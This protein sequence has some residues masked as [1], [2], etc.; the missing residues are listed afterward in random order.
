MWRRRWRILL[1][2]VVAAVAM[3]AWSASNDAVYEAEALLVV[4]SGETNLDDAESTLLGENVAELV[5]T[6]PVLL[7]AAS[8]AGLDL[9]ASAARGRLSAASGVGSYVSVHATGPSPEEARALADG[10]AAA[11]DAAIDAQQQRLADETREPLDAEVERVRQALAEALQGVPAGGPE[12]AA[13]TALRSELDAV[14]A[15]RAR[16][17]A[18]P[19]ITVVTVQPASGGGQIE[20]TPARDAAVIFVIALVVNGELAVLLDLLSGRFSPSTADQEVVEQLGLPVL[21]RI[22]DA[23]ADDRTEPFRTLRTNL[24]FLTDERRTATGEAPVSRRSGQRLRSVAVLSP[25][26]GDGRTT[27]VAGL[28]EAI[29]GAGITVVAIDGDL[30]DPALHSRFG[31]SRQPGLGDVAPGG[32]LGAVRQSVLGLPGLGVVPAGR[33]VDDPSG[34]LSMLQRSIDGLPVELV[35]V[36]TP[37]ASYAEATAVAAQCDITL[38][39][40]DARTASKGQVQ[41]LLRYLE[42]TDARPAGVVLNRVDRA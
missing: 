36:D 2:S 3:G 11:V 28:A 37:A 12:P 10:A 29:A 24:L 17:L 27:V 7:D 8:R 31:L 16:V 13:A 20:P 19:R 34:H 1:V 38:L 5:D 15:E 23:H 6:T 18:S 26:E 22:P 32:H 25:L 30:R 21:G 41:A 35:I 40:V 9:D 39:V 4:R 33:P 14:V 42:T